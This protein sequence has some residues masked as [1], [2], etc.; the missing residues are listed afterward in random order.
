MRTVEQCKEDYR[1]FIRDLREGVVIR[2]AGCIG[3]GCGLKWTSGE[4]SIEVRRLRKEKVVV[5]SK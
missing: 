3:G 2:D 1:F 5:F 4:S